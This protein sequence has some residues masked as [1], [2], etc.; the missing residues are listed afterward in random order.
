[1]SLE[2]MSLEA[3]VSRLHITRLL[4]KATTF[5]FASLFPWR[6]RVRG[7]CTT[8]GVNR[9]AHWGLLLDRGPVALLVT[10]PQGT[11]ASGNVNP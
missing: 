10:F 6:G 8:Q 2:G 7:S 9:P 5:A 1:M 4:K 3:Q 11:G